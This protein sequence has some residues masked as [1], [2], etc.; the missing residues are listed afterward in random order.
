[1]SRTRRS[2]V[3]LIL[4]VVLLVAVH[5]LG[6]Y[7]DEPDGTPTPT[8]TGVS[9]TPLPEEADTATPT[10]LPA[11]TATLTP[12]L[13]VVPTATLTPTATIVPTPTLTPTA[14]A[15]TP[16]MTPHSTD[17]THIAVLLSDTVVP[18]GG[19]ANSEVFVSLVD[20]E[21]DIQRIELVLT[22]DPTI[23][24][25]VSQ[26]G[27]Q[28]ATNATLALDNEHGQIAL[29]LDVMQD[30]LIENADDWVK[31]ATITWSAQQ[32]GKS[33]VTIADATQFV[34]YD[35][36]ARLPDATYNGVVFARAP[37]TIQGTVRL[38][39]RENHEGVSVSGALSSVRFD[40][41]RTDADGQFAIATSH[42]EGFY[43][44]VVAMPGYLSAE[45]DRPVK[46]TVDSVIDIG[47]ITLYGGDVNGDNRIDIRDLAYVAWHF[48]AYDPKA[49][50]N[51]DG[52]VD[53]LDL[54]LTTG[55]F[56]RQG[57]DIWPMPSPEGG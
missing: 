7:A 32:E 36:T 4:G 26:G 34:A 5:A 49:D 41:E 9:S 51:Q 33:V 21:N 18:V 12:T 55:N 47:E 45:G 10:A 39:G 37:G 6:V 35:G 25:V 19:S 27:V 38:Q 14:P 44:I 8:A 16:T 17:T 29:S 56:G 23:V 30:V 15:P 52:Q 48:D 50:I 40:R 1:M 43:T 2:Q 24:Q 57:P 11:A 46:M 3:T 22:F 28:V 54:T 42:G 20:V 31:M 53:I 13:E